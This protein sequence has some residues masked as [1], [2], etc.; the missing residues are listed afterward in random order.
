M[1]A[2]RFTWAR[3][4]AVAVV[5]ELATPAA[6]AQGVLPAVRVRVTYAGKP[7]RVV[8]LKR[9]APCGGTRWSPEEDLLV[10]TTSGLRNVLVYVSRGAPPP[11]PRDME[12]TQTGC[13]IR[14]R[15]SAV[16]ASA[17]LRIANGD[18][19]L[20]HVHAFKGVKTVFHD[21]MPPGS[22]PLVRDLRDHVG[23]LLR[24]RCDLHTSTL[25]YVHVLETHVYGVT[26]E[27]GDVLLSDLAAGS[28]TF[29]LWHERLGTRKVEAQVTDQGADLRVV[30]DGT[31]PH[32]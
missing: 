14:P 9:D 6:A 26:N 4:A 21:R 17:Q 22:P 24:L 25:A 31:E 16:V 12:L 18:D 19:A 23:E 29:T 3:V 5:L 28:Y 15:V 8:L 1:E 27:Q 13:V 32:P 7:P 20:H 10:G 11:R 30:Y 2:V